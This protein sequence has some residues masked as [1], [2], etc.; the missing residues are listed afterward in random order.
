[1]IKAVSNPPMSSEDVREFRRIVCG[2]ESSI[3]REMQSALLKKIIS[4]GEEVTKNNG[5]KNPI[6]EN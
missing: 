3:E 1:M 6:L 5:G 2:D 4:V